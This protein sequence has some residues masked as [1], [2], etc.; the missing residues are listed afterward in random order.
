MDDN[1]NMGIR[2][3]VNE[4][5]GNAL[6]FVMVVM[7]EMVIR[8]CSYPSCKEGVCG[9]VRGREVF[10]FDC[11]YTPLI[12]TSTEVSIIPSFVEGIATALHSIS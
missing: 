1:P 10:V 12:K 6:C 11:H 2:E 4:K 3:L 5:I 7:V 8:G 9:L